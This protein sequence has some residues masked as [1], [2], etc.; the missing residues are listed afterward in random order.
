MVM[1]TASTNFSMASLSPPPEICGTGGGA[2]AERFSGGTSCDS[3]PIR[4]VVRLQPGSRTFSVGWQRTWQY[5]CGQNAAG[6]EL[7]PAGS[8]PWASP[9]PQH[10]LKVLQQGHCVAVISCK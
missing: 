1:A 2:R 3:R 8:P 10:L 7:L 5:S 9:A 4:V 6:G